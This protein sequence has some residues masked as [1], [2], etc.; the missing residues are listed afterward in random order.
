MSLVTRNDYR[1]AD[2]VFLDVGQGDCL[3]IHTPEGKN[4]LIDGG[5]SMSY[6]V[7]EK[8][9]LPYLLKK[10]VRTVDLAIA[11]HLHDD[12]YLGLKELSG[13]MKITRLGLYEA[14][15]IREKEILSGTGLESQNL[16]YLGEGDRILIEPDIWIDVLYPEKRDDGEYQRLLREEKDENKSSLI[17]RVYYKG[18]TV[19]MTGDLGFDGEKELIGRYAG[20]S[21]A[22]RADVL[23]VGHHG[24]G[25]STS[26]PFVAAVAPRLAVVQVG[27]ENRFGH[28]QPATLAR[29]A[30]AGVLRTD[31]DGLIE[32]AGDGQRLWI[33]LWGE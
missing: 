14:N 6:Q 17:L 13:R 15:R 30:G 21:E 32:I 3:Y 4:L 29:L 9:L 2:L 12:H 10:G 24:S 26:A 23:K 25:R 27:A 1:D 18:M 19:L 22:L 11:T 28:P 20:D 8:I 5:G 31:R 16:L 7:G 33:K